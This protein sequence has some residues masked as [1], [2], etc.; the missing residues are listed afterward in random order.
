MQ[1][2]QQLTSRPRLFLRSV[3]IGAL[4][5]F[6][7]AQDPVSGSHL[8]NA[9]FERHLA[10][11]D[12]WEAASDELRAP[13]LTLLRKLAKRSIPSAY[14]LELAMLTRMTRM[15]EVGDAPTE[16]GQ[17]LVDALD[18]RPIPGVFRPAADESDEPADPLTVRIV[19]LYKVRV[20]EDVELSLVWLGPD[21]QEHRVRT[22]PMGSS[23][24][25]IVGFEMYITAPASEPGTWALVPELRTADGVYRGFP[26][27]V[28]CVRAE[29]D[30]AVET[31]LESTEG[32]TLAAS[33][34]DRVNHGVRDVLAPP[35]SE[36]L[37]GTGTDPEWSR[38]GPL[39]SH[40]VSDS[41]TWVLDPLEVE[42]RHVLIVASSVRIHPAWIF[43]GREGHAW[44]ALADSLGCR[45]IATDLPLASARGPNVFKLAKALRE[46]S[47]GQA[48]TLVIRGPMLGP[49]QGALA[50]DEGFPFD[51]LVIATVHRHERTPRS[52]VSVPM[53]FFE[54]LDRDV[55]AEQV[56]GA[57]HGLMW[58]RRAAPPF[59]AECELPTWIGAW[60]GT[61]GGK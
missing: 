8:A 16:P 24:D 61:L 34:I 57:E 25:D 4:C 11:Q 23:P 32:A 14:V 60:L 13:I 48:V 18:L 45:V 49:F 2:L 54:S 43:A 7:S 21:G 47:P 50:G 22:E 29:L 17:H 42:P 41:R 44:S 53:L 27:P 6:A 28:E 40:D 10:L 9:R 37:A 15:L 3:V 33:L 5:G 19:S 52:V 35:V 26:V 30:T 31:L 59:S 39:T 56:E 36:L 38:L 20:K 12:A 46:E 1:P 58:V 51:G 55:P